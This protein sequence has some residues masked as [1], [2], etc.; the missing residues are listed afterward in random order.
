MPINKGG[1]RAPLTTSDEVEQFLAE[2]PNANYGIVTGTISDLVVLD[3]DGPD[4]EESLR[5]LKAQHG[6][7]PKTVTVMTGR[8]Y[9][10]Y[11]RHPGRPIRNSAK[12]LGRGLDVRGEGGYVV[13]VGSVHPSGE[14]Y[15]YADGRGPSS[16]DIA[17]MPDWLT[18]ILTGADPEPTPEKPIAV[19]APVQ[20]QE[21]DPIRVPEGSRNQ[22]LTS[23][24][25][26]LQNTGIPVEVLAEAL[27]AENEKRCDPPLDR[28]EVEKIAASVGRYAPK[29]RSGD[30]AE[31]LTRSV[32]DAHFAGGAQLVY[33]SDGQFWS[34]DETHWTPLPRKALEGIVLRAIQALPSRT[35]Q[36]TASLIGQA[37]TLLTATTATRDDLLRFNSPPLP[38]INCR[39]GELWVGQDGSVESEAPCSAVLSPTLPGCGLRPHRDLPFV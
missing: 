11:F 39:N 14:V 35:G 4:G 18:A 27:W 26:R 38:V 34:F 15:E 7:L 33:A 5:A 1:S 29:G 32:L 36:R 25:G 16:V 19:P 8:G 28:A 22:H 31:D 2:H 24:A 12:R 6:R 13:G 17:E 20:R 30:E 9:H 3:V 10:L 37:L 23:L 21:A